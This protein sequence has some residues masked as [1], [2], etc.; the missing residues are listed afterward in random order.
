MTGQD[1]SQKPVL[2]PGAAAEQGSD[3]HAPASGVFG[4]GECGL[5]HSPLRWRKSSASTPDGNC[6]ELAALPAGRV[7]IRNSRDPS[8]QMLVVTGDELAAL[9]TAVRAGAFND[10]VAGEGPI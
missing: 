7:G 3:S 1:K 6:V 4:A 8:G 10:L 5:R 2:S 9:L